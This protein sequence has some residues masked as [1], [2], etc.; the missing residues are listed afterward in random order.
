MS[1]GEK[2]F[3]ESG[4]VVGF[5]VTRVHPV[6]GTTMEVSFISEIKGFGK[7]PSGRNVGSGTMTQYPHGVVDVSYQGTFMIA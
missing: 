3:E 1:L 7:F 5:K 6:E 4:K 2:L